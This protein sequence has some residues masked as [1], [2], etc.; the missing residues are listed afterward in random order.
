MYRIFPLPIQSNLLHG[1]KIKSA[2]NESYNGRTI[3][4]FKAHGDIHQTLIIFLLQLR[5]LNLES[6]ISN[7][8]LSSVKYIVSEDIL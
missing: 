5:Y 8:A 3:E 1:C 4:S 6:E 7:N 2:K